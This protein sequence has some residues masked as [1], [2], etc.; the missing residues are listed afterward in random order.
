MNVTGIDHLVL[1]V[2]DVDATSAFYADL[3]DA[4]A[5]PYGPGRTSV[6]L[7][8]VKLNVR[9]IEEDEEGALVAGAPTRGA[10]DFCLVT[11]RP[12][13]EV[14]AQLEAKGVEVLRGPVERD[15]ARG[16]MTSVYFRDPA[17]N[18]VEIAEYPE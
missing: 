17:G 18:L 14:P 1:Y 16:P 5:R 7:G 11:D 13:D 8:D 4:E 10:G 3:F 6:Y 15:G 9:P 12:I 2:E